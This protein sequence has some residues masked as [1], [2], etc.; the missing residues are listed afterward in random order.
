MNPSK[1]AELP[2]VDEHAT[3]IEAGPAQVWPVLLT[4]LDQ[5]F[6]QAAA[7][8][9]RLVG[10][11]PRAA[12]GARPLAVGSTMPGFRVAASVA[13]ARLVLRGQH[14]FSDYALIF[15]LEPVAADRSRLTAQSRAR[16]PGLAGACY[17]MAVIGT[18]GHVLGVRR[19]LAGV[20]RRCERE[21]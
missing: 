14:W 10:A 5:T 7:V 2:Y 20:K 1:A 4:T 18:G 3:V 17:R 9:G 8:Y 15:R 11:D 19:L 6:A 13:P 21:R 12:S 16:F